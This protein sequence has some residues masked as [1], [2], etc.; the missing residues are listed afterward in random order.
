MGSGITGLGSES[1][2]MGSGS[3]TSGSGSGSGLTVKTN[4]LIWDQ[5]KIWD[6]DHQNYGIR[7][8]YFRL[9]YLESN[10][11]YAPT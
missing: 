7:G 4:I 9:K 6:Q 10:W 3:D 2:A 1:Q 8:Q 11:G 5:K